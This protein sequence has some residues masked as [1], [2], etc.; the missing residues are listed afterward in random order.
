MLYDA[1]YPL[2]CL[3]WSFTHVHITTMIDCMSAVS[4]A[5]KE[6]LFCIDILL[7]CCE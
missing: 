1:V 7:L 3:C 4:C 2:Q 5:Y 6:F